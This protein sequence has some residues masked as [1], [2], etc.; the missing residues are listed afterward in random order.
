MRVRLDCAH[1]RGLASHL[2]SGPLSL[3]RLD[4]DCFEEGPAPLR[5]FVI[6]GWSSSTFIFLDFGADFLGSLPACR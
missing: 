5:K 3:F 1:G 2:V 6:L 4:P